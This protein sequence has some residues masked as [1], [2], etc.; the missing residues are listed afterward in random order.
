MANDPFTIRIFVP[1]GDPQGTRFV[2]RMNWTGLGIA[3]PREKWLET[4][5]R[6]EMMYA[7]VYILHGY[8][9]GEEDLPTLYIGEGDCV[10]D[11]IDSHF[12]KK[13]FWSEGILFVSTNRGLNKAHV[14][15]LEYA[16]VKRAQEVGQ[17]RLDNSNTPGEAELIEGEKADTRAFLNEIYQILPL[18]GVKAFQTPKTVVSVLG[19]PPA[20]V[21]ASLAEP[22]ATSAAPIV[23]ADDRDTVVVPAKPDGFEET[24]LG[25]N[26]WHAIRISGGMLPKIRWIAGYQIA[27]VRAI[28]HYAPVD[29][30]EPY[31]EDN[32]YKLVFAEPAKAIGPIPFGD[33]GAGAMQGPR[34]TSHEKL[35]K[36]TKLT[37]LF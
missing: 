15:W 33:A 31:G 18:L 23:P 6:K 21:S 35:L 8:S 37:D 5:L 28:T 7:G 36:A 14:Q 22:V 9:E 13:D 29:H 10:R 30:I 25:Q 19:N 24:F 17:C 2:D 12:A 32:K 1:D 34:Y 27:P 3:F 20:V 16:L 4:R 26:C 11:R